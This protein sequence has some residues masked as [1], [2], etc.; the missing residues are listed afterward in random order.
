MANLMDL[1]IA[2][3]N[4]RNGRVRIEAGEGA[5]REAGIARIVTADEPHGIVEPGHIVVAWE[6]GVTTVL[7][8]DENTITVL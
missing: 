8:R 1:Q 6:S 4:S 3:E 5:D 7:P 2:I